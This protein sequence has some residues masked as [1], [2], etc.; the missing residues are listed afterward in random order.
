MKFSDYL[1]QEW[2]PA[3]GC[4]EPAS[5]ALAAARAAS[6][7][8][9]RISRVLLSVDPKIYKNCYAV[10]IPNSDHKTG[11][12][13]AVAIGA[14]LP[15]ADMGLESFRATTPEIIKKAGE[16]I[17]SGGISVEVDPS[18]EELWISCEVIREKGRGL[19]VIAGDHTNFV[20]VKRDDEVTF[21]KDARSGSDKS[22]F[23]KG[24][25]ETKIPELVSL[26]LSIDEGDRKLLQE[27]VALNTRIA[28]HGLTLLP[29]RFVDLASDEELTRIS[30][31]V[32]AGVYARMCGE[33]F[34][35]MSLAGSGNKGI[36]AS[37]PTAIHG[38]SAGVPE[39]RIEESLAL[40]CLVTSATTHH[41]GPLSAVCGCSNAAG[42]GLAAGLVLM[43][44]GGPKEIGLAI[45]N[46]VGNVTGMIC[47][48]A[49]IG[50]ALKTMTAVDA[51]FRASSLAL[52]GMGIPVTDGIVGADGLL[53]LENLGRIATRGMLSTDAEILSIMEEKL[54]TH[55][56]KR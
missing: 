48:G 12:L 6:E 29:K 45:N 2:V 39:S 34:P 23:R 16:L 31:L 52:D 24:I 14:N 21:E 38:K 47:D 43:D 19:A 33:D 54:R 13:W 55:P 4:T 27:G 36:V 22:E 32:C 37:V 26:A 15:D 49:K 50:C 42:I 41:L 30:K 51:A 18:K 17:N 7:S 25:A 56:E 46:M 20:C 9:G 10:G 1:A 53:S 11:I 3:L 28:E 35:V 40:A 8:S 44:G 5:I